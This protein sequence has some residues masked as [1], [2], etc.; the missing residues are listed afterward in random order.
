MDREIDLIWLGTTRIRSMPQRASW[1]RSFRVAMP[2]AAISDRQTTTSGVMN[3]IGGT[4]KAVGS[5]EKNKMMER[6][7]KRARKI[8]L[9]VR[10]ERNAGIHRRQANLPDHTT[11]RR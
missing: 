9:Y 7:G 3:L 2:C 11:R 5:G 8:L 10:C 6:S 4:P 1:T